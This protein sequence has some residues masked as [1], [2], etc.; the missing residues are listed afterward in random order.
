MAQQYH[1]RGVHGVLQRLWLLFTIIEQASSDKTITNS[2]TI[3]KL[4]LLWGYMLNP[5]VSV[6]N[7]CSLLS[8]ISLY[9]K[10][11]EG[12]LCN[13]CQAFTE[14]WQSIIQNNKT[15][16]VSTEIKGM[17]TYCENSNRDK[18][19]IYIFWKLK[20]WKRKFKDMLIVTNVHLV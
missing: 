10:V 11:S 4:F 16:I 14:D 8:L 15:I 18:G 5:V 17:S 7:T 1:C 9:L 12:N 3:Q 13:D 6:L 20:L 19:G 2:L